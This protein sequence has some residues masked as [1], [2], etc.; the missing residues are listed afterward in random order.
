MDP[1]DFF[2]GF[3]GFGPPHQRNP[4]YEKVHFPGLESYI[5]AICAL[6]FSLF[7]FEDENEGEEGFRHPQPH[8]QHPDEHRIHVD[9]FTNPLE[10]SRFFNRQ[11][12]EMLKGFF[13]LGGFT[14]PL[15]PNPTPE[16]DLDL[17]LDDD[18]DQFNFERQHPFWRPMLVPPSREEGSREF[19][20]KD[21]RSGN[22][23][24]GYDESQTRGDKDLDGQN[25]PELFHHP[26]E[27]KPAT[28]FR[29]FF[30]GMSRSQQ[31]VRM[32]DGSTEQRL[33][34]RN[35]DGSSR[36]IVTRT[37]GD[38]VHRVTVET[39]S[40]GS[41]Q[42]TEDFV[43]C[44]D[45]NEFNDKQSMALPKLRDATSRNLFDKFFK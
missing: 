34:E 28:E 11:M 18:E 15:F 9:V 6:Y 17:D 16:R 31:S 19:M 37:K 4:K 36:E 27:R 22:G 12:D 14:S 42:K 30:G 35:S 1:R 25:F 45:I 39:K 2:R 21:G 26:P 43:N 40:D 38:K 44:N 5:N 29:S 10:M 20:L 7:P 23:L 24:F 3:F 41:S 13:G 33:S 32:G 8:H